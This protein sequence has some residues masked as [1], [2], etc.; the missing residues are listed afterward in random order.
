VA[1]FFMSIMF[2]TIFALGVRYL[3]PKTKLGSS[4]LIMAIVGGAIM[5]TFMGRIADHYQTST[6]FVLPL[7]AFLIAASFGVFYNKLSKNSAAEMGTRI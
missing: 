2:P 1:F 6:S 5:P 4:C 7:G 3:G